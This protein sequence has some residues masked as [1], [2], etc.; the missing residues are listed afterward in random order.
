MDRGGCIGFVPFRVEK[1]ICAAYITAGVVIGH[2]IHL[3][4]F[5][6]IAVRKIDV[7]LC[8][9][10][11]HAYGGRTVGRFAAQGKRIAQ[12][13]TAQRA[14]PFAVFPMFLAPFLAAPVPT[15]VGR[16]CE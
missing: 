6:G 12:H 9:V 7:Q 14:V 8:A 4:P 13:V 10:I 1:H 15:V 2:V 3:V 5:I 16:V 11:Q